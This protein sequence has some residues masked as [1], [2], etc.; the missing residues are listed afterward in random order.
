M[1]EH[2]IYIMDVLCDLYG[3]A[4]SG[5]YETSYLWDDSIITDREKEFVERQ[6]L[7][8]MGITSKEKLYAW[9]FGTTEEE[10]AK[11]VPKVQPMFD[12][13]GAV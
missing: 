12:M 4:P 6:A 10:A 7:Q 13:G 2:A 3:L 11:Q 8:A 5:K 9:Y 1:L